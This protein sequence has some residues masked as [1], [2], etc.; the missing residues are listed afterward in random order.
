MRIAVA[1]AAVAV[2][3]PALPARA[4]ADAV[5]GRLIVGFHPRLSAERRD[6]VLSR[7]RAH[8]VRE[9]E[10][11]D[12]VVVAPRDKSRPLRDL[13][14]AL[15]RADGV[16]YAERDFYL[17]ATKDPD[18]PLWASQYSLADGGVAAVAAPEAWDSRTSCSKV[19]VLD[20]GIQ[21]GHPDLKSNVWI[22][23]KEIK[24]NN[25]DD[26]HN[27]YVD[28]YQ[29]F[30]VVA[31]KGSG[32]DD[33]GHGTHVGGIIAGRGNNDSGIAGLC[34]SA[35]LVPVKFLDS[36][37]RGSTS[38]AIAGIDYALH[39][40]VKVINCSFGT[41]SK[42][43]ALADEIE[44]AQ[45][46]G[47]LL[48]V[49]AGN[50]GDNIDKQPVYPAA[51]T[52]SNILTVAATTATGALASFSNFGSDAVDLGAPGDSILSTYPTSTYKK[53]SGTSMAAPLV[54]AAAAL[55]RGT[56]SSLSYKTI[57]SAI[58]E[59]VRKTSALQGKT[60]SGGQLDVA[61]ALAAVTR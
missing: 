51:Y 11:I 21:V 33:D 10:R 40:G 26:D 48:V 46:K 19:A 52:R 13:A 24:N 42:S 58:R 53:L 7:A 16:R 49:A 47:T 30:N 6:A 32:I 25:K 56:D 60:H 31:G 61:Q 43:S 15:R 20:T 41:S 17:R 4:A 14:A 12:A 36:R 34:W 27:K 23:D 5:R 8:A 38:D 18:D 35:N 29:G 3:V 1:L 9:L 57:R 59:H 28:D 44:K 22:N 2:L 54:A 45:D 50:D 55:L 39:I 37:G